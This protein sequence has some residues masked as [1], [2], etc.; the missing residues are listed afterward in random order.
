VLSLKGEEAE[1]P[2]VAVS[3]TLLIKHLYAH[4]LLYSDATHS[5]VNPIFAKKLA[6]KPSNMDVQVY[7]TT[8][9]GSTYYTDDVFKNCT[10]HLEGRVL[11]LDLV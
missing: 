1:N 3:G 6:S 5:F 8:P 4:V 2:T 11:P 10:I 9:F 7:V